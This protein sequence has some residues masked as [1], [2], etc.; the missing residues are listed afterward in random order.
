MK[1]K[2]YS[3]ITAIILAVVIAAFILPVYFTFSVSISTKPRINEG[4]IVPDFYAGHW[5]EITGGYWKTGIINSVIIS[6]SCMVLAL[7]I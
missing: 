3:I 6:L 7:V 4:A 5:I 2:L 1:V